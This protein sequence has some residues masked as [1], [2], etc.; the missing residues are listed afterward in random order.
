MSLRKCNN[1]N[2]IKNSYNITMI[3]KTKKR[4]KRRYI[5]NF[6][7]RKS[8]KIFGGANDSEYNIAPPPPEKKEVITIPTL[9][10]NIK[11]IKNIA[12]DVGN[13]A[14]AAGVQGLRNITISGLEK[15]GLD[16]N[17]SASENIAVLNDEISALNYELNNTEKG[18]ELKKNIGKLALD[19]VETLEPSIVKS[20][21]VASEGAEKLSKSVGRVVVTAANVIPPVLAINALS[22]MATAAAH[23]GETVAE[24]T[25]TGAEAAKKLEEKKEEATTIWNSLST[26]MN[27]A[28]K[29]GVNTAKSGVNILKNN[30]IKPPVSVQSAGGSLKKYH[31]T[32]KLIGG[33]ILASKTEFLNPTVNASKFGGKTM[34]NNKNKRLYMYRY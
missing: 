3:S 21:D 1:I 27:K 18:K 15:L 23:A 32:A 34:R 11:D 9:N 31:R 17:A 7:K 22:N 33:R 30:V 12:S 10:E 29:Q 25:S 4:N 19:V 6:Q 14:V 5:T 28:V 2:K 13:I 26:I 8:K 16:P 24:L 20:I